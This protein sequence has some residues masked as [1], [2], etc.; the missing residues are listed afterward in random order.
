MYS[1]IEL[2]FGA[3]TNDGLFPLVA[4]VLFLNANGDSAPVYFATLG[5]KSIVS[6]ALKPFFNSGISFENLSSSYDATVQKSPSSLLATEYLSYTTKT[7][8]VGGGKL[9]LLTN[10]E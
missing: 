6:V 10:R 5:L 7:F 8:L 3:T 1:T 2:S 4:K 9:T